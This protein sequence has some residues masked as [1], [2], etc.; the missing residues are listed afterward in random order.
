[1]NIDI[2]SKYHFPNLT[3]DQLEAALDMEEVY[4]LPESEEAQD[5]MRLLSQF[6]VGNVSETLKEIKALE[7][8]DRRRL[9]QRW[10]S[11]LQD[12]RELQ[13]VITAITME[14]L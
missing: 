4:E 12:P 3:A 11:V 14:L 2:L 8:S 6:L 9:L 7:V 5:T 1:M 13:A 10:A